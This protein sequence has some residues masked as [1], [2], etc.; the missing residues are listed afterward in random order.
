MARSKQDIV[1]VSP[2]AEDL[3]EPEGVQSA[4]GEKWMVYSLKIPD[5]AS[6]EPHLSIPSDRYCYAV[7]ERERCSG[8]SSRRRHRQRHMQDAM[9]IDSLHTT[10]QWNRSSSSV[11]SHCSG[12]RN[13]LHLALY[14]PLLH[15]TT[16]PACILHI[17]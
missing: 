13:I 8:Q 3:A 17:A 2:A 10:V 14:Q 16:Q 15:F 11:S 5:L 1:Y 4:G 12:E 6:M 7:L 9:Y